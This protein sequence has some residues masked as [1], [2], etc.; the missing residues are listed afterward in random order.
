MANLD[1]RGSKII[2]TN[3]EQTLF[4]YGHDNLT[5]KQ[6][7]QDCGS[8]LQGGVALL[9]SIQSCQFAKVSPD[10]SI[11]DNQNRVIPLDNFNQQYIFE[12]RIF[13]SQYELRWL[14]LNNGLG[15]SAIIFEKTELE[16]KMPQNW[17]NSPNLPYLESLP[18][19]YLLWGQKTDA[20]A[21]AG[22]QKLSSARIGTLTIPLEKDIQPNQR[23][24]LQTREYLGEI[25][26]DNGNVA[27]IEERLI[28][29]EVK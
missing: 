8:L 22:W 23:V 28:K 10:N 6:A 14:N 20:A 17:Q 16:Q 26:C 12:A 25:D 18:Q 7:L 19:Q 29:L 2:M 27:V 3:N 21:N 1:R 5:L 4:C 13:N 15:R 24:Y 9:Y 11:L